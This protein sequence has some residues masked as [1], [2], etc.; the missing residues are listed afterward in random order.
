[1]SVYIYSKQITRTWHRSDT[2]LSCEMCCSYYCVL[3]L[4]RTL[5]LPLFYFLPYFS[6]HSPYFELLL[7]LFIDFLPFNA[8]S[9]WFWR[10]NTVKN[11]VACLASLST[12][13]CI[14]IILNNKSW[15]LQDAPDMRGHWVTKELELYLV[16]FF[17]IHLEAIKMANNATVYTLRKFE[18]C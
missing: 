2:S 3:F 6:N 14:A 13:E 4:I 11:T 8:L 10:F 7:P 9:L 1:M 5:I 16:R 12:P 18:F 17:S 15:R